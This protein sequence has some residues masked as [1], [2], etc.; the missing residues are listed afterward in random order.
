MLYSPR[1]HTL[2]VKLAY[3]KEGLWTELPDRNVTV[4]E[5]KRVPPV[6]D[7]RAALWE[8]L[9]A[10][11][12][13]RPVRELVKA[14]DTVAIAFSDI[15]RPQPRKLML[16]VLLDEFS[17]VPRGQIVLINGLGTHRPNTAEELEEMLGSEIVSDYRVV[18]HD[19]WD[20]SNVSLGRTSFGHE[21]RVSAEYMRASVRILTGFIEPHFFAGFSGGPK[22]VLPG[23]ADESC[24]LAN[25]GFDMI[26]HP[27][28]TWGI[29]EGNPLWEEM[30]EVALRTSPT[31][32]VNVALKIKQDE[33]LLDEHAA[34]SF[35]TGA[36]HGGGSRHLPVLGEPS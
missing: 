26:G 14:D 34:P 5:P 10:P 13:T 17:H 2:R 3:G 31:F 16:S 1:G 8:A 22:A 29:T 25:H 27:K 30:R 23:L 33:G 11:V 19:A 28:V 9:R 35:T 32:L 18:Q 7:E 21:V 15:T 4:V 20:R 6:S 36:L 12:G 24:I